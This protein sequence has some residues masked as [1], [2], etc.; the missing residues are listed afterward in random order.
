MTLVPTGQSDFRG[1]AFPLQEDVPPNGCEDIVD[2]LIRNDGAIERRGGS[3]YLGTALTTTTGTTPRWIWDGYMAFGSR[4]VALFNTQLFV[5]V[6]DTSWGSVGDASDDRWP[7]TFQR[8][9]AING[10][11]FG[12]GTTSL[13]PLHSLFTTGGATSGANPGTAGTVSFTQGS[14]VVTGSGTAFTTGT[15]PVGFVL[16]ATSGQAYWMGVASVQS[17]TQITLSAPWT[18]ATVSGLTY[19]WGSAITWDTLATELEGTSGDSYLATLYDRL[20][21]ARERR[22]IFSQAGNP[23]HFTA[24]D[25]HELSAGSRILGLEPLGDRLMIFTTN[26][27]W[28]LS[29]LAYDLTDDLGNPQQRLDQVDSELVL[30]GD[31]GIAGWKGAAVIPT[32][33]NVV[34]F[35]PDGSSRPVGDPIRDLYRGYVDA[36]YAP[37]FATVYRSHYFLP[38]RNGETWVDT[39]VCNL[40]TGAWSRM[41]GIFSGMTAVTR[42]SPDGTRSPKFLGLYK[43]GTT[44]R[45]VDLTGVFS[46]S[47]TVKNDADGSA[48]Q[49][50]VTTRTQMASEMVS[51]FWKKVQIRYELDDAASDNPT[52]TAELA[53]GRPASSFTS[54]T[55]SAVE[56]ELT[57]RWPINQRAQQLRVRITSNNA[58]SKA[59]LR[60]VEFFVRQTGRQTGR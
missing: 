15:S 56:G 9:V 36:G 27:V 4:T 14:A 21:I 53:E 41:A 3:V 29:N 26:G 60:A 39:L 16:R 1:G 55:G 35:G 24:D 7:A 8:P 25:Y 54:L 11:L 31:P 42:R 45:G 43:T 12:T 57:K 40:D 37:G 49:L 30:W 38:I 32:T 59:I 47:S 50:K 5:S 19:S 6:S 58:T 2:G 33:H 17:A 48:H 46:P 28:A 13:E 20:I 18:G 51:T 44:I 52:F 23:R 22:I 34:M 10:L